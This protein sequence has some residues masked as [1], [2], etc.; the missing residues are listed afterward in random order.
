MRSHFYFGFLT[1][2]LFAALPAFPQAGARPVWTLNIEGQLG[3]RPFT[4][5]Y[6]QTW[7][8]QQD[9]VS[10]S[11]EHVL[12]YQVNQRTEPARLAGRDVSGGAGN[13][14]LEIMIL[15]VRDGRLLKRVQLPTN[16]GL[17]K[18]LPTHDG[19]MIVRTGESL[20]LCK[21][22]FQPLA[23]RT[24]PIKGEAPLERWQIGV[25][26]SGKQLVL[27]H[28]QIR[29][30]IT[31]EEPRD[32][33]ALSEIEVLD[34]DTLKTVKAFNLPHPLSSWSAGENFLVVSGPAPMDGEKRFG[35]LDFEG[36]WVPFEIKDDRC[37]YEMDI[38]A[39]G[40]IAAYGCGRVAVADSD[41]H[42]LFSHEISKKYSIGSMGL[43]GRYLAVELAREVKTTIAGTN[44]PIMTPKS[45]RLEVFDLSL[46]KL[47]LSL[48]ARSEKIYYRLSGAGDLVVVDGPNVSLYRI[49]QP[50]K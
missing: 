13:F 1:I 39:D 27:V 14:F 5:E 10:L 50:A 31:M 17:S 29:P 6:T 21:E 23:S 45:E 20:F 32:R 43:G 35:F 19:K 18:I 33:F 38:L 8:K 22:D 2:S 16:A 24:L 11:P 47:L 12:V 49:D 9:V 44:F 48:P 40:Y 42:K 7:S 26:P 30:A 41:G 4:T 34:A 36:R 25:S 46:N 28:Q 3:M 15:D 37:N